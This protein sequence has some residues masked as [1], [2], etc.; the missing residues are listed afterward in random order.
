MNNNLNDLVEKIEIWVA[1]SRYVFANG[2]TTIDYRKHERSRIRN[3]RSYKKS[4]Y[5]E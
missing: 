3:A 5:Y 1:E 2:K 4:N